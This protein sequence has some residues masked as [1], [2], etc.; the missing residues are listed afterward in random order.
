MDD[1]YTAGLGGRVPDLHQRMMASVAD[2]GFAEDMEAVWGARWGAHDELGRLRCVLTRAPSPGLARVD[3]AAWS[4]EAGALVD[5]EGE[6][7]WLDERPPDLQRLARQ[8]AG[9]VAALE[10]EGVEV[11]V[12]EPAGE[13]FTKDVYIRDPL[14]TVPGGAIIGRMAPRMRRGEEASAT[15]IVAGRGMPIIG[16]ITSGTMEGGSF[17]KLAP[18]L[19]AVGVGIRVDDAGA[20]CLERLLAGV[21]MRLLR[22]ALPGYSIH[23]D[24]HMGMVDHGRALVD[25]ARLPYWFLEE[26]RGRGIET[27]PA[28]PGETWGLNLLCL[29]PGVVLMSESAPVSAERLRQAGIDV[30]TIPYDEVQRNGGGV[31][32]STMELIREPASLE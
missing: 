19:A 14:V 2:V 13:R 6:W 20:D 26:L 27:I 17:V 5:P 9:L 7:Y 23:L 32:C 1:R 3:P 10:A 31:H 18:D 21:G 11:I 22:V 8:H 24:M 25:A 16:T 15:R 29:R 4:A 30:R 28:D 12:A